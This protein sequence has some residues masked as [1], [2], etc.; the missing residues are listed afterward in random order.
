[1]KRLWHAAISAIAQPLKENI[2]GERG[3]RG[4]AGEPTESGMGIL[5]QNTGSSPG[6]LLSIKL[7]ANEL[8]KQ[9]WLQPRRLPP[10]WETYVE[11]LAPG[12]YRP[13]PRP[14]QPFSGKPAHR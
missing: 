6:C 5:C 9:W 1:M 7:P 13:Q 8:E 3:H 12:F 4:T 10:V 2:P 14:S 11:L